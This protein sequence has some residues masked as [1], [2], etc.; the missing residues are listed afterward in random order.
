MAWTT[1][2][3][4]DIGA[5]DSG[6]PPLDLGCLDD[7]QCPALICD[8]GGGECWAYCGDCIRWEWRFLGPAGSGRYPGDAGAGFNVYP[9]SEGDRNLLDFTS[10]PL[11]KGYWKWE[12]PEFFD[13]S[14]NPHLLADYYQGATSR[15]ADAFGVHDPEDFED[16]AAHSGF[17]KPDDYSWLHQLPPR[18]PFSA[19]APVVMEP[20]TGLRD[21]DMMPD[22]D[23]AKAQ[24]C[25][26]TLRNRLEAVTNSTSGRTAAHIQNMINSVA[27]FCAY[28]RSWLP[29]MSNTKSLAA[30]ETSA[31][32]RVGTGY[33][34][35]GHAG[36]S[37]PA[38]TVVAHWSANPMLYGDG[39]VKYG[40][41]LASSGTSSEPGTF[42]VE[43]HS[44][45]T[46]GPQPTPTRQPLQPQDFGACWVYS[47]SLGW[48]APVA[49]LATTPH[50][51]E[52]TIGPSATGV[53]T[54]CS[55]LTFWATSSLARLPTWFWSG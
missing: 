47:P 48:R 51:P 37:L 18:T 7:S 46:P 54:G 40:A 33:Y 53:R 8:C 6:S 29:L 45:P 15:C 32:P 55:T 36:E 16:E 3:D 23:I 9:R 22:E 41:T 27:N 13:M 1:A 4:P 17:I 14:K 52:D 21:V 38:R 39:D 50:L 12:V 49:T 30:G 2:L 28:D 25:E 11:D 43:L 19:R 42:Q 35:N 44:T 31:C 34:P 24:A 20:F 26:L 10:K 5:V